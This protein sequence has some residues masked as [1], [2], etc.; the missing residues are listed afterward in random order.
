MLPCLSRNSFK[1]KKKIQ[2]LPNVSLKAN[3]EVKVKLFMHL[4]KG[5]VV[6]KPKFWFTRRRLRF[7]IKFAQ[8]AFF[9]IRKIRECVP[10]A[11][12]CVYSGIW[13]IRASVN[14]GQK[15]HVIINTVLKLTFSGCRS[16]YA[17]D[18]QVFWFSFTTVWKNIVSFFP[19]FS[20]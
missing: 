11:P 3:F 19:H 6:I 8:C 10:A 17:P 7:W 16:M 5:F 4:K 14:S 12:N 18:I 20:S 9:K 13:L 15:M 1:Q 2:L